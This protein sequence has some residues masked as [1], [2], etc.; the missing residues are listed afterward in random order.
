[1]TNTQSLA[2]YLAGAQQF[3]EA[4][5]GHVAYYEV[6]ESTKIAH[7][8][9]VQRLEALDLGAYTPDPPRDDD[10]FSR[11]TSAVQRK[12][13]PVPGRTDQFANFLV[14]KVR[15]SR[16]DIVKQIVIEIVDAQNKRLTFTP[17]IEMQFSAQGSR[18]SVTPLIDVGD[19]GEK[20]AWDLA[21]EA[22]SQ[23]F[24]WRGHLNSDA[25]RRFINRVIVGS[26]ATIL[27][28]GL[29]FIPT[30]RMDTIQKMQEAIAGINGVLVHTIP[31]VDTEDQRA[32]VRR[33]FQ[34]ESIGQA[35]RLTSQINDL[36]VTGD[37]DAKTAARL[38]DEARTLANKAAEYQH[39]LEGS[40][41]GAE[42]HLA[43]LESARKKLVWA[44]AT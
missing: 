37:I 38:Q 16:G 33:A 3:S 43:A 39:L 1:M 24:A 11:V 34:T 36:L 9:F 31:L 20:Q 28:A 22:R 13:E 14:R 41:G 12:R 15:H 5:C 42:L 19:P 23:F 40:L 35:Q 6:T 30:H 29:Y 7:D 26:S 17:A 8:Q 27:K 25:I 2:G 44:A 4:F 21:M 10:A 18:F 32:M